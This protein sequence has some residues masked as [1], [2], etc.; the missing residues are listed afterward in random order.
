MSN[1][2]F[3]FIDHS[4]PVEA[5][6]ESGTVM[7]LS[8]NGEDVLNSSNRL[9]PED[10]GQLKRS[11]AI[12]TPTAMRGSMVMIHYGDGVKGY[13]SNEN[14]TL[15]QYYDHTLK[16]PNPRSPHSKS[17]R[18]SHWIEQA[19]ESIYTKLHRNMIAVLR[20]SV[21]DNGRLS[22]KSYSKLSDRVSSWE[23]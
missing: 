1:V 14:Y 11:G 23:N 5:L 20:H 16:H 19:V 4:K 13:E 12:F 22:Q 8:L 2:N 18:K 3:K 15:T 17:G 9:V 6:I 21:G 10:T 7:G